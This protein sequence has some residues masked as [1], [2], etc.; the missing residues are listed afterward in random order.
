MEDLFD[1]FVNF[2]NDLETKL[3]LSDG[4]TQPYDVLTSQPHRKIR[5]PRE[6]Y[7]CANVSSSV[8]DNPTDR[9]DNIEYYKLDRQFNT[10][11]T[12]LY[13]SERDKKFII[14]IRGTANSFIDFMSDVLILTGKDNLSL[15]KSK[16]IQY[17]KDIIKVMEIEGYD[18]EKSY[19]TGHSLG[20]LMAVYSIDSVDKIKGIGFNMGASPLQSHKLS[21]LLINSNILNSSDAQN[22]FT[23]YI[24]KGDLI[25]LS[26]KYLYKDVVILEPKPAPSNPIE[27]HKISFLIKHTEPYPNFRLS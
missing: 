27:A 22:R 3:N 11:R 1:D 17:I 16:Q 25:S 9:I 10:T 23:S 4:P 7:I 26:S 13:K 15:R 5:I 24:M 21:G 18:I 8:Y 6:H 19:I 14:G 20:G 2:Y 12:T